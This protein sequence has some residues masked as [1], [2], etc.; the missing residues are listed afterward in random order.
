MWRC[1]PQ[2]SGFQLL[3]L[4]RFFGGSGHSRQTVISTRLILVMIITN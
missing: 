3:W 4:I 2:F 1:H